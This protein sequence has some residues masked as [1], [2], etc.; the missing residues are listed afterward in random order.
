MQTT[1]CTHLEINTKKSDDMIK[2]LFLTIAMFFVALLVF[3]NPSS[4]TSTPPEATLATTDTVAS[5]HHS[6]LN[7]E[8]A[9]ARIVE[10]EGERF[11]LNEGSAYKLEELLP[12][13]FAFPNES[14]FNGNEGSMSMPVM[15]A[16]P[17]D[18]DGNTGFFPKEDNM[19]PVIAI[20]FIVPCVTLLLGLLIVL[21]FFMRKTQARNAI[22]E[23]AID[24]NYVLP[25]AFYNPSN[26]PINDG[27]QSSMDT[28]TTYNDGAHNSTPQSNRFAPQPRSARDPK[29]FSSAVT[30]LAVG[31]ALMLFFIANGKWG[32]AFLSGGLPFF[33]GI[34]KLI[35][36]FYIP[37]FKDDQKKN[38]TMNNGTYTN[39]PYHTNY[40]G[41]YPPPYNGGNAHRP[42]NNQ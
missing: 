5:E 20:C 36:Y 10:I 28:G 41:S 27:V 4:R 35:G 21:V 26:S 15:A 38:N 16:M 40:P 17:F 14:I 33:L 37:G 18:F 31:F 12:S 7:V 29:S 24:A 19:V 1:S 34:G 2:K 32:I 22:I 3:A 13:R 25:D 8:N 11:I 6:I 42:N 23:K 9:S 39:P 30:L